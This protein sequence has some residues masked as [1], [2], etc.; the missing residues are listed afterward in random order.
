MPEQEKL[1][2]KTC[3]HMFAADKQCGS[4][5]MRGFHVCYYHRQ[6]RR[7]RGREVVPALHTRREIQ[8]ALSNVC[9]ALVANR[10]S[11]EDA[12]RL[13]YAIQLAMGTM[14]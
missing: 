5:A 12:G 14:K 9:Q 4:P 8:K 7:F 1:Q 2:Y 13:I 6:N 10:I 3:E 11:S